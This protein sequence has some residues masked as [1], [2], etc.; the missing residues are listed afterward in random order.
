MHAQPAWA[1]GWMAVIMNR[2]AFAC[3]LLLPFD[4][5]DIDRRSLLRFFHLSRLYMRCLE[6]F[7]A[8]AWLQWDVNATSQP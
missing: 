3:L 5:V 2:Y 1:C 7:T 8:F 4:V 6:Q